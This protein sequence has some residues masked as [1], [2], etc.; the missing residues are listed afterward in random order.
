MCLKSCSCCAFAGT[1][2]CWGKLVTGLDEGP[3]SRRKWLCRRHE[4]DCHLLLVS[5]ACNCFDAA[6]SGAC[7]PNT[8]LPP[9]FYIASTALATRMTDTSTQAC[10]LYNNWWPL[11][12]GESA[13]R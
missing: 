6:D 10:A 13:Q 12:T 11:L 5:C 7:T 2:L 1:A 4:R 9:R 3:Q 8:A